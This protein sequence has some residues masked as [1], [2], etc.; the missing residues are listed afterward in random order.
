MLHIVRRGWRFIAS[1][2]QLPDTLPRRNHPSGKIKYSVHG[3][4][5]HV[6]VVTAPSERRCIR[7]N[8]RLAC[9]SLVS[10]PPVNDDGGC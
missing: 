10:T 9:M 3:K 8:A 6:A 7:I 5:I 2:D 4:Q 1:I